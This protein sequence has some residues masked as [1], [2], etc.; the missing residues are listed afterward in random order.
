LKTH[1]EHETPDTDEVPQVQR[2]IRLD[3]M[4]DP[5][6][7]SARYDGPPIRAKS[8][9]T[10]EYPNPLSTGGFSLIR[11]RRSS[12]PLRAGEGFNRSSLNTCNGNGQIEDE[13]NDRH[14]DRIVVEQFACVGNGRAG[15][16]RGR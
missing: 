13:E 4:S 9:F 10:I 12:K 2:I 16:W 8:C 6:L 1:A 14:T 15:C 5:R 3:C 11:L 7:P